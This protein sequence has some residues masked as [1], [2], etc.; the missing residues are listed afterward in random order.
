MS[1]DLTQ[2]FKYS[3]FFVE[4]ESMPEVVWEQLQDK[5][6]QLPPSISNLLTDFR[7]AEFIEFLS[8]SKGLSETQGQGISKIVR[9]VILAD[10]YLGDMPAEISSRLNI[11]LNSAR[12]LANQIASQVFA[13]VLDDIKKVQVS[14]F[15]G[16]IAQTPVA[17]QS[18]IQPLSIPRKF[19]G[20]DL[21]ETGGNIIDLRNQK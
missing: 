15:P 17:Q 18:P 7:T 21:P 9:D 12:E 13:P 10:V 3:P 20:S 14:R 11:D 1:Q 8:N 16:R 2:Y 4:S 6:E 19:P 5:I